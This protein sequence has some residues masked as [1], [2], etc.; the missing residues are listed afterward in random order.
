MTIIDHFYWF[1]DF[2]ISQKTK[3]VQK[4]TKNRQKTQKGGFTKY[5]AN[6]AGKCCFGKFDSKPHR[7]ER[8]KHVVFRKAILG[9]YTK[10][11]KNAF[12]DDFWR[13]FAIFYDLF[14]TYFYRFYW[15]FFTHPFNDLLINILMISAFL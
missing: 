4:V 12:F 9:V 2:M 6:R 3:K 5:R 15:F 10:M 11:A 8:S 13:F 7:T 1:Y 14:F